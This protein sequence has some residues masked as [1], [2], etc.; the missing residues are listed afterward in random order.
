MGMRWM[1]ADAV[2]VIELTWTDPR[3]WDVV[4]VFMF[5]SFFFSFSHGISITSYL[6]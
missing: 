6:A 4:M 5:L 2:K 3:V 1:V